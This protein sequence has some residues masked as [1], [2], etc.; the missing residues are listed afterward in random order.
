VVRE[1][2]E[3]TGFRTGHAGKWHCRRV[4][5]G[6]DATTFCFDCDEFVPRLDRE[7]DL[8]IWVDPREALGETP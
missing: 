7:H 6:V 2:L 8:W 4:A 5:D 3:E 1:V